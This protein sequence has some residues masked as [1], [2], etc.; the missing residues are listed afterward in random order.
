V[1]DFPIYRPLIYYSALTVGYVSSLQLKKIYTSFFISHKVFCHRKITKQVFILCFF[2]GMQVRGKSLQKDWWGRDGHGN[3]I[4]IALAWRSVWVW[5]WGLDMTWE[6]Q[7][8]FCTVGRYRKFDCPWSI[9]I[10][11]PL[12]VLSTRTLEFYLQ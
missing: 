1:G 8:F 11:Q 5:V 6:D 4:G 3:S 2:F 12:T 7:I 9:T 10:T